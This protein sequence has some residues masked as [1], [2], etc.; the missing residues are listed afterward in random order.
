MPWRDGQLLYVKPDG[1]FADAR[2]D[3]PKFMAVGW[4]AFQDLKVKRVLR[5]EAH[6]GEYWVVSATAV[7]TNAGG[8]NEG[9]CIYIGFDDEFCVLTAMSNMNGEVLFRVSKYGMKDGRSVLP[10]R[11]YVGSSPGTLPGRPTQGGAVRVYRLQPT[12]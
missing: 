6:G 4:A 3:G 10:N 5:P 11:I 12:E 1:L 8:P 7:S 2:T 9:E